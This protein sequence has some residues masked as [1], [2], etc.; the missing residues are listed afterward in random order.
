MERKN[1]NCTVSKF[2]RSSGRRQGWK[3]RGARVIV[4]CSAA[5]GA[6]EP[7]RCHHQLLRLG[8]HIASA[9]EVVGV[10]QRCSS[11]AEDVRRPMYCG[12]KRLGAS[13]QAAGRQP[14]RQQRLLQR[15]QGAHRDGRR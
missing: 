2:R 3:G 14:S 7:L 5:L 1:A 9:A 4:M 8:G 6:S 10:V 13:T 12:A 11:G 15:E